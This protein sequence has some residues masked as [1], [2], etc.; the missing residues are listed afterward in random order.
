[1]FGSAV[2]F[3]KFKAKRIF[4]PG[5]VDLN[6]YIRRKSESRSTGK[7]SEIPNNP[8]NLEIIPFAYVNLSNS[9]GSVWVTEKDLG[10]PAPDNITGAVL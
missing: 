3:F 4:L 7:T 9:S 8:F 6:I 1:M 10:P 5:P 2:W